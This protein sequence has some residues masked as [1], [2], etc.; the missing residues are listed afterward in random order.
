MASE[1]TY[2]LGHSQTMSDISE[3]SS[4]SDTRGLMEEKDDGKPRSSIPMT[5]FN[6]INSII[7]SGIIGMPFALRQ[8]GFGMGIILI[9]LVAFITDFSIMLLVEGG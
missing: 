1:G 6:F 2:I 3:A 7:G 5:S 9:V 4:V 8:A